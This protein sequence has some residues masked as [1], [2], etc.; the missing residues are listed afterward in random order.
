ML[1]IGPV[2]SNTQSNAATAVLPTRVQSTDKTSN[3]EV[4]ALSVSLA[5][6]VLAMTSNT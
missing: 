3:K 2:H 5:K 6:N 4:S 1:F